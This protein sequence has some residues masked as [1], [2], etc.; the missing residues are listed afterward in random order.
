MLI[1]DYKVETKLS[2]HSTEELEYEAIA[3]LNIDL[4]PLLPYLNATLS[5]AVYLPDGS[6]LSWRFE[7][8]KVGFWGDR[9]AVDH[10]HSRAQVEEVIKYLVDLVNKTWER[11]EQITPD[12]KAHQFLQPL[13]LH[14][15]LPQINCKKCG[16]NTCFNFALKIAAG[17]AD[18]KQCEPLNQ[19]PEFE[20]DRIE[21]ETLLASKS[22]SL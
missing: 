17:Q 22:P 1:Q 16:E 15:L 11:R 6:A 14:R 18:L 10:L 3:H 20:A 21:L 2:T 4:R 9:I 13:E 7:E 12:T 19:R 8:H 5:R